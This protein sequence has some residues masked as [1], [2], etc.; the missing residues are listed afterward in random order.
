MVVCFWIKN[1]WKRFAC[2]KFVIVKVKINSIH[3]N[4]LV[5]QY[6]NHLYTQVWNKGVVNYIYG[7]NFTFN[8][9]CI[10]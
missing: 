9:D 6:K 10:L 3:K 7:A 8:N 1:D 2:T 4:K 5:L